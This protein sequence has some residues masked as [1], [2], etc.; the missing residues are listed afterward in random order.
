[1][2]SRVDAFARDAKIVIVTVD[3][4]AIAYG[5]KT[6]DITLNSELH[7]KTRE[8]LRHNGPV[9]CNIKIDTRH[10]VVPQVKYGRPIEDGEPSL[11][12]EEFLANMII[13]TMK[14]S[15]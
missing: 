5:F 7:S 6:I 2:G 4:D 14:E 11:P 9:F 1:M 8:T 12:R 10:R 13:E 3:Q 15:L